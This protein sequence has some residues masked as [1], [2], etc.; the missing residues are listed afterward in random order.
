M[1]TEARSYEDMPEPHDQPATGEVTIEQID[2]SEALEEISM[3]R[4][5]LLGGLAVHSAAEL[6]Y[7]SFNLAVIEEQFPYL[8]D[9]PGNNITLSTN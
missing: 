7:A 9:E 6:R 8:F 4:E 2:E 5:V 3:S 1:S